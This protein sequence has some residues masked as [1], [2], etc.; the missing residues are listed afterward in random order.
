MRKRGLASFC[1]ETA[2]N[3]MNTGFRAG[4]PRG[5]YAG[6]GPGRAKNRTRQAMK[7]VTGRVGA[8]VAD[9]IGVSVTR[10]KLSGASAWF[11]LFD[12]HLGDFQKV[13]G[14]NGDADE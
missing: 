3:R 6:R 12:E 8:S 14:Q 1:P 10:E 2:K 5:L 13:V 7:A 4:K 9:E 11:A